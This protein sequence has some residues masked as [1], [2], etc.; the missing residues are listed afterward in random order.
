[1]PLSYTQPLS[2]LLYPVE[3][4][5][6]PLPVKTS[7]W[8]YLNPQLGLFQ[9]ACLFRGESKHHNPM[10]GMISPSS[11]TTVI[12][13]TSGLSEVVKCLAARSTSGCIGSDH[14]QSP[15]QMEVKQTEGLGLASDHTNAT[16]SR[17]RCMHRG[18]RH[19]QNCIID[20]CSKFAG[21]THLP[22]TSVNEKFMSQ[23]KRR[24][25]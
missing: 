17:L 5:K 10:F 21:V 3:K 12:D 7:V 11:R 4:N 22:F 8:L 24:Q 18:L 1:M 15:V 25:I 9:W 2:L 16:H 6:P 20:P 13:V 23:S 14:D 19:K